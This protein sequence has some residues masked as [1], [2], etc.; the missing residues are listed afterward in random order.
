MDFVSMRMILPNWLASG[1]VEFALDV[2]DGEAGLPLLALGGVVPG[3]GAVQ[4]DETRES[5]Q[6]KL[7]DNHSEGLLLK[8]LIGHLVD[9]IWGHGRPHREEYLSGQSHTVVQ[10]L[11]AEL[12]PHVHFGIAAPKKN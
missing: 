12:K 10:M 4:A 2:G 8:L 1:L 11:A 7:A 5:T 3:T 9:L 6:T